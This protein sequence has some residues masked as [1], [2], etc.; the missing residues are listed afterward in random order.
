MN[1]GKRRYSMTLRAA[2]AD[3]TK[4]RIRQAA[5]DLH[6]ERLWDDFTLDEVA[7]RAGTTVQTVLRIF[8]DKQAL[9]AL[10]MQASGDR[11]RPAT[12]PGD[13]P[14]AIRVLYD[15]YAEI[16]ERVIRYLADELRH[17]ALA[18]MVEL[19]RQAH[20]KWVQAAF[21]SQL[22]ARRG[23]ARQRLLH[24]LIAVTDVY[25]WKLL[26]RD[27]RLDRQGAQ[28]LVEYMVQSIIRGGNNDEVSVGMLGRRRQSDTKP[29]HRAAAAPPRPRRDIR[30][31]G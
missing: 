7:A 2:K 16:G 20:R 13:I 12:P 3:A 22:R 15:D 28:R 27:L 24:A 29:G 9:A 10:A 26:S 21:A 14:A 17:P 1:S 23:A 19:G 30:R 31:P 6:A 5:V 4:A 18:P 8:G 25:V 11:E